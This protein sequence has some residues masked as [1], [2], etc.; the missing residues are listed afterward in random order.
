MKMVKKVRTKMNWNFRSA[1]VY[2]PAAL[3]QDSA[4]PFSKGERA[5]E[6][7]IVGDFLIVRP[8]RIEEAR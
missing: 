8:I 7:E 2:L 6:V 5:V 3:A 1:S 4:F